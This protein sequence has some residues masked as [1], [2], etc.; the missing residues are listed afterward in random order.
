MNKVE[1][2]L[3]VAERVH[4]NQQYDIYPYMYHIRQTRTKW[5]AVETP[6]K[7]NEENFEKWL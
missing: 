7:F 4:A 2:A 5:E 3:L 1:R 6:L